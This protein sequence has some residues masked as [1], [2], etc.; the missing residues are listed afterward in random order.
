MKTF[1]K[2]LS[3][4][5]GWILIPSMLV[6][7]GLTHHPGFIYGLG[8]LFVFGICSYAVF[9]FA[10][11]FTLNYA[12]LEEWEQSISKLKPAKNSNIRVA[13]STVFYISSIA[14]TVYIQSFFVSSLALVSLILMTLFLKTHD[15]LLNIKGKIN[16]R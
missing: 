6:G 4:F 7:H 9:L 1:A 12:T 2:I 16:V 14:Y 5:L 10:I 11:F 8:V 15:Y 13:V 3:E